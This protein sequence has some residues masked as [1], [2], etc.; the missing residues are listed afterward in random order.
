MANRS[1]WV[2]GTPS[3]RRTC[4]RVRP[5]EA[6]FAIHRRPP[7]AESLRTTDRLQEL[8]AGLASGSQRDAAEPS[9]GWGPC[10]EFK[11]RMDARLASIVYLGR[12]A[13]LR[14]APLPRATALTFSPSPKYTNRNRTTLTWPRGGFNQNLCRGGG[15]ST[16]PTRSPTF[17]PWT[18]LKPGMI[19][20]CWTKFW[21]T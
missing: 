12:S 15:R 16:Y 20:S 8:D 13:P 9:Y 18:F 10:L 4:I 21:T 1:G 17:L 11:G 3:G 19:R 14:I 6:Q 5:A 2:R 7:G